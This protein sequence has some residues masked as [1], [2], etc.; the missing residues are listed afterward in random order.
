MT[1]PLFKKE[2]FVE[3]A[4][5]RRFQKM[6]QDAWDNRSWHLLVA[7]PGAGKTMSIRDLQKRAGGRSVLAVV[8]PKNN[9]DEQALGDQFLAALGLPIRGHWSTRKPKLMGHLHQYGTE[10]LIVDDAHDLSLEHLMLLKEVTDQG[11]LQYDHPLGLCLVAAGRGDTIPLKETFDLPD[12]TWLQFRRRFD[13][14]APFCRVASHTSEEVRDILATLEQEYR[15]LLPQLRL[16]QWTGTIYTWLTHPVLD[17]TRSGR[18]T[19]DNLMKLVTT[20]LEWSYVAGETDMVPSRLKS[21]AEL[22]VLRHDTLKLIDGAGPDALAQDQSKAEPASVNGKEPERQT[23]PEKDVPHG[24]KT[25]ETAQTAQ[26]QEHTS[27]TANCTFSG[28]LVPIDLKRFTDSGIN[29]V[30]CPDCGRMRSL[31]PSKGVLRFKAHTRR[32]QQTPLTEK[33]WSATGKTDWDVVGG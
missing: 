12:P 21:A 24:A 11:R 26:E 31:S 10:F 27:K 19:M 13:K 2:I 5:A 15:P 23:V 7:D 9:D 14:L 33:R 17:P 32:K 29:L 20:A 1:H 8:A 16:S 30:E 6:L 3:T 22:L 28:E 4:F 18:V 25:V